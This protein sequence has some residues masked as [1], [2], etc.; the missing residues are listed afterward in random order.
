MSADRYTCCSERR[1]AAWLAKG[2]PAAM[3]GID[4]IEVR[5]G[6]HIG[7]PS[8]I[9]IHLINTVARS[10]AELTRDQVRIGGGVR[11][12]APSIDQ[13]QA[14]PASGDVAGYVVTLPGGQQTD[15]STY[16]L[17]LHDQANPS[18]PPAFID[19]RLSAVSFSFKIDC[20]TDADCAVTCLDEPE[21]PGK[22]IAF[23]YRVRDYPGFRALM[24]DRLRALVPGFREDDPADFTTTLVEMLA[25]RADQQSYRLDWVGTE[26]FLS[27]ARAR[28]S[29]TRH[30][31][32]LDYRA[33]EGA[34][35][36]VFASFSFIPGAG[37]LADGLTLPAGT[38]LLLREPGLGDVIKAS[39]YARL[40]AALP[41]VFETA[42]PLALWAWRNAPAIHTWG[43]GECRLPRGATALTLVW[44]GAGGRL[45]PGELL[46][47]EELKS[48]ETGAA[49]D[50]DP[51]HRHVVRL[52]DVAEVTDPLEPAKRLL[53]VSWDAADALPFDLVVAP[54]VAPGAAPPTPGA[55]AGLRAN[56]MLCDHGMSSPPVAALALNP[57]TQ[58]SLRPQL[59]PPAP[60]IGRAWRPELQR[61]RIA[62]S[63]LA[64]RTALPPGPARD[65]AAVDPAAALPQFTLR[66]D[67]ATW[68]A[69][70]DLLESGSYDRDFV[71]ETAID[72]RLSL[73]F[74]DGRNGTMP[75]P[76]STMFP[77]GRFGGGR[78]GNVGAGAL[79][80]VVVRDAWEQARI[81]VANPLAASGG[82]DAESI[83][84]I[85]VNAPQAFRIQERAVTAADYAEV[86]MR[87]PE[88]DN[89]LAVPR[90]T[91]A[92]Q[93]MLVTVDRRGGLPVDAAFREALAA[94]LERYR[95]MGFDVAIAG[96]RPAP[97]EVRLH[98]CAQPGELRSQ[99]AGRVRNALRPRSLATGEP[100]F[101]HP[102][103]FTFGTP[104][105]LSQ[106]VDAV[107]AVEGV[108]S[109]T[110]TAF[111]RLGKAALDELDAG[112]LRP[113]GTEVFELADDPN[114]PERGVLAIS[115]GG[116]R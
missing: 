33:N 116:G 112:V 31:R 92:W 34:S 113:A 74:G 70:R 66:D 45:E 4:Y 49:A 39:D 2:N 64:D 41:T 79:G 97:L 114:F 99:V 111:K 28:S 40:A 81:T 11:F 101:F 15:F 12:P 21:D 52:T 104:I 71:I 88:V 69:R 56:V 7:D 30:A 78:E 65:L 19:P 94:H 43:D 95:L 36:R 83:A 58:E 96:A 47:L 54:H 105:Y 17:S 60:E 84:Q 108:A 98:V 48:P 50:A 24:L 1:R 73:R 107:M 42:A 62:R 14:F 67:F 20:P 87:H 25:A 59:D 100:G 35:A 115:M 85:R 23:D 32:L 109:V 102:D 5:A 13:V 10:A 6:E 18:A 106:L 63:V 29:V 90:W 91:G 68:T 16:V 61:N 77:A 46:L 37:P 72:G 82:S 53:T 75:A 22:E 26:A 103:R 8:F 51:A 76:G 57:A 93:T 9:D 38:P 3:T 86:A 110:P 55:Y 44:P 80:H 89:A 27:T